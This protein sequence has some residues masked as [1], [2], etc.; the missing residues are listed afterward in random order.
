[1]KCNMGKGEKS[2]KPARRLQTS[3]QCIFGR[4]WDGRPV[5]KRPLLADSVEKV[6]P[7]RL[8]AY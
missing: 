8:P 1:M 2:T 4:L 7:S 3:W 5:R 6:G